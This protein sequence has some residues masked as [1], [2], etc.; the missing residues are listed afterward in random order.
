MNLKIKL[1]KDFNE[2]ITLD[3]TRYRSIRVDKY[4]ESVE[5]KIDIIV[6]LISDFEDNSI[7]CDLYLWDFRENI[8]IYSNNKSLP[9]NKNLYVKPDVDPTVRINFGISNKNYKDN[10]LNLESFLSRLES[11]GVDDIQSSIYNFDKGEFSQIDKKDILNQ[12]DNVY[13]FAILIE[14][15]LR[16]LR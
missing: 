2:N 5:D 8:R 9:S 16:D 10:K 11:F 15:N 1:F 6:D 4:I 3:E 7:R 13:L 12:D 14:F